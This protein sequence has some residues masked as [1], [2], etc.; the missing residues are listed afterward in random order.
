[1]NPSTR[2]SEYVYG[3]DIFR[4]VA[5][6]LVLMAHTF[7]HSTLPAWLASLR[8]IGVLGVELF[9]VLSGL[10][11]GAI[12]IRLID[13]GRLRSIADIRGFWTRRWLRTLPLYV[14]LYFAFLRFDY[15]GRHGLFDYPLYLVFFQ[16][17]AWRTPEFFELSWSLAVE[18]HF[19]LWF[20]LA[21]LACSRVVRDPRRAMILAAGAFV[22]VVY[23]F[24]CAQPLIGDFI[25][26]QRLIRFAVLSRL[27]AVMFGVMI[28]MA[29][30]YIPP[31]FHRI[32]YLTPLWGLGFGAI[33]VWYYLGA[34][35][36]LTS[37]TLQINLYTVQSIICCCLL[38]RFD[39]I[40][41]RPNSGYAGF[42]V[43][44]SRLAYS[45]Y[46]VHILVIIG[47]N[48]VLG[49]LG[50]FDRIY[51]N[52]LVIYPIYFSLYYVAA[53]ITYRTIERPFLSLRD[54]AFSWRKT[55]MAAGPALGA[56]VFLIAVA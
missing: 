12:L 32:A 14:V 6:L 42:F 23:V 45:L 10:L 44:T 28:A 2:K 9:F 56:L 30:R 54:V 18:E 31:L 49:W 7:E 37:H 33:C 51:P 36:I 50:L 20:P 52:P 24:R 46:L 15:H 21:Y 4:S 29:K 40:K 26:Y 34:P 38:P 3:L 11:I 27:D 48:G 8:H 55:A 43:V 22:I 5:I 35:G 16:N 19:Y 1:M 53:W 13:Q 39:G 25:E 41:E 17:F 47:V